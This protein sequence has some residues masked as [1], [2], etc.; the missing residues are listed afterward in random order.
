MIVYIYLIIFKLKILMLFIKIPKVNRLFYSEH[1]NYHLAFEFNES[2]FTVVTFI[3]NYLIRFWSGY[4]SPFN[5]LFVTN[6]I[7]KHK[8]TNPNPAKSKIKYKSDNNG[9]SFACFS[10]VK[11]SNAK[12]KDTH[13]SFKIKGK[14]TV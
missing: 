12:I 13:S 11:L 4:F 6:Q 9:A 7:K 1:S 5:P 10:N 2:I 3:L 8:S 14:Y